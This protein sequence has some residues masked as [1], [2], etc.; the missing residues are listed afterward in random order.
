PALCP[1]RLGRDLQGMPGTK[2]CAVICWIVISFDGTC[3]I[4]HSWN[5]TTVK[6]GAVRRCRSSTATTRYRL[7]QLVWRGRAVCASFACLYENLGVVVRAMRVPGDPPP[8]EVVVTLKVLPVSGTAEP[9]CYRGPGGRSFRVIVEADIFR[10]A[11][12][13]DG[14]GDLVRPRLESL[15]P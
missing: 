9:P 6:L 1:L 12:Q 15:V 8:G 2:R 4:E 3:W 5:I 7:P 11:A 13:V 14:L 10:Q